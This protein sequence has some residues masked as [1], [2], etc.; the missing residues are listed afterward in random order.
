M[1][2]KLIRLI[3]RLEA[4]RQERDAD[5][6]RLAASEKKLTEATDALLKF[7]AGND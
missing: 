4:A 6:K 3:H 2:E 1:D 5:A 7:I